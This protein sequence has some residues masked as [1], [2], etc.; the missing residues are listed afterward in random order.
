[1]KKCDQC[2]PECDCEAA[3]ECIKAG[4]GEMQAPERA[5]LLANPYLLIGRIAEL[6]HAGGLEYTSEFEVLD[7]IRRITLPWW[8]PRATDDKR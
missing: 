5:L 3:G 8:N 1:M 6:A 2:T 4:Y 7:E